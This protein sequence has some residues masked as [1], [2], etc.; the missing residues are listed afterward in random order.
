[1]FGDQIVI[2]G[3]RAQWQGNIIGDF[4]DSVQ[5]WESRGRL[6]AAKPAGFS[7]GRATPD[8]VAMARQAGLDIAGMDLFITPEHLSHAMTAHPGLTRLQ[9]ETIP[10]VWRQ[11]DSVLPGNKPRSLEM[12]KQIIG[13]QVMI[14]YQMWP[15][16]KRMFVNTLY[17]KKGNA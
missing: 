1:M 15:Q 6:E 7:L 12:R 5:D 17:I 4:L 11:P 13:E 9:I 2:E 14:T 3:D 10:H 8:A 16:Q